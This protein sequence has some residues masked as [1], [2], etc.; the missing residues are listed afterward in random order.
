[1]RPAIDNWT[2][3]QE[4]AALAGAAEGRRVL[5]VGTYKGFGAVLMAQAGAEVWA[6]DWHRGDEDLG[7]RD[8]LCAWWTNVRRHQVEDRVVGLV[9]RSEVVLPLLREQSFGMAFVD[10][11]HAY[12]AVAADIRLVLP[13][14]R[15]PGLVVFHDYSTV[16]P[17]VRRAVDELR[18]QLGRG[19][20]MRIVGSL[21]ILE[22]KESLRTS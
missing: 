12:E 7:P 13:L 14:I 10:A 15:R 2:T 22:L 19:Y 6:V 20:P 3:D 21:A 4:A 17:G 8:T 18:A 5:E 9:G 11:F 16:W 1:M